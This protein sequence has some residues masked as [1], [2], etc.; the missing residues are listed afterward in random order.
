MTFIKSIFRWYLLIPLPVL[1]WI[2]LYTFSQGNLNLELA[3]YFSVSTELIVILCLLLNHLF[4]RI[5]YDK[6]NDFLNQWKIRTVEKIPPIQ[7]LMF[8]SVLILQLFVMLMLISLETDGYVFSISI[9]SLVFLILSIYSPYPIF[10]KGNS[11]IV[12][13]V[14]CLVF[15]NTIYYAMS[16]QLFTDFIIQSFSITSLLAATYSVYSFKQNYTDSG[17][18]KKSLRKLKPFR[19]AQL[20]TV[21]LYSIAYLLNIATFL[22]IW[23]VFALIPL[24]SVPLA[25]SILIKIYNRW[26]KELNKTFYLAIFLLYYHIGLMTLSF[27]GPEI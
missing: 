15:M 19:K 8:I 5:K 17:S 16:T 24:F 10:Q 23:K 25:V 6:M 21:I 3:V 1:T 22:Y 4:Q 2:F 12:I 9:I 20:I 18:E 14:T 7:V 13:F 27:L 11:I 26:G